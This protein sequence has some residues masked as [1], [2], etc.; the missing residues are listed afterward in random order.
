M[1]TQRE[2]HFVFSRDPPGQRSARAPV[3]RGRQVRV[4]NREGHAGRAFCLQHRASQLKV[5]D[6]TTTGRC[7]GPMLQC[8]SLGTGGGA[9][10]K[11]AKSVLVSANVKSVHVGFVSS[12]QGSQ[13]FAGML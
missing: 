5:I 7:T 13:P 2:L 10:P 12:P 3:T 6:R 8:A 11:S 9:M 1:R 4:V